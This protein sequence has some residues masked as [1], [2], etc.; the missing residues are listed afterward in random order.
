[1]AA[2]ALSLK[3]RAL[4]A[5]ARREYSRVELSRKLAA[6]AESQE[7]LAAVLDALEAAR[8]LSNERFA[9][10]LMHRRAERFGVAR[11]RQELKQHQ[12][13]PAIVETQVAA[14]R[15][16][17]LERARSVWRKR[18]EALPTN[19][20][21]RARQARFLAARGFAGETIWR[22]LGGDQGSNGGGD[23]D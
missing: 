12:L 5:L 3:G 2:S 10:S 16:T 14:L 17:E 1:M 6:H 7:Q 22:V 9:E 18:Y 19:A 21:E 15:A 4:A 13:A 23:E 11:I 20:Q 8:L